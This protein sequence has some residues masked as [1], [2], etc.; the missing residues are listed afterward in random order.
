MPPT[1]KLVEYHIARLQDKSPEARI[2]AIRELELL[3]D[4]DSLEA[5]Q[6][7]FKNDSDPDVR[8][9]AQEAGRTLWKVKS[10]NSGG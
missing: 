2:K 6:D 10:A 8:K 9:A 3:G 5:L 4:P 1:K 7:V